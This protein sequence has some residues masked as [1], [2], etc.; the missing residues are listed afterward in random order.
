MLHTFQF[1]CI[2]GI[3]AV[4]RRYSARLDGRLRGRRLADP[5]RDGADVEHRQICVC[6][7]AD[8]CRGSAVFP[9]DCAH[10]LPQ[11]GQNGGARIARRGGA[12]A[13]RGASGRCRSWTRSARNNQTKP[14]RREPAGGLLPHNIAILLSL[15]AVAYTG[16]K[17]L[18]TARCMRRR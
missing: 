15:P 11:A 9:A 2:L 3:C 10:L 12:V 18:Q 5:G 6:Q 8:F 4:A 1:L 17:A 16:W 13:R 14:A 7:P